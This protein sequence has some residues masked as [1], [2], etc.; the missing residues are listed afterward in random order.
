[1]RAGR[2][3]YF[4][5]RVRRGPEKEPQQKHRISEFALTGRGLRKYKKLYLKTVFGNLVHP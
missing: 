1:M 4:A 5:N 2:R 3:L